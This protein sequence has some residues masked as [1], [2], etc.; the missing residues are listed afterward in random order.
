[1]RIGALLTASTEQG[2]R[3]KDLRPPA[4]PRSRS[5]YLSQLS[6]LLPAWAMTLIGEP[7]PFVLFAMSGRSVRLG[8]GAR[9]RR[10]ELPKA[11]LY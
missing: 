2:R 8:R 5:L 11:P 9:Y 10:I 7:V 3:G 1:M 4:T 6:Q